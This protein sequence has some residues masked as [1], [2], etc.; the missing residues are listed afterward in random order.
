MNAQYP[1]L[2]LAAALLFFAGCA[3]AGDPTAFDL[4]KKGNEYVGAQSKG[5]IVEIRSEKSVASMT[6]NIW[7]VVYYDPDATFK[8]IEVKFGA[9]QKLDVSR[10]WR[11]LEPVTGNDRVLDKTKLK[12]DSTRALKIALEQPLLK[13]LTLKASQM[14]L[15][16]GDEGPVWEVRFWAAKLKNPN[17]NADVGR[18]V[19]SATDGSV[20]KTDF[21]PNSVD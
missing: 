10:P 16:H 15:G 11:A 14:K 21:H 18:V 3:R 4:A 1:R 8:S 9:G 19:L 2:L 17:E 5:K 20:V 12:V 7:Y 6:P 13:N